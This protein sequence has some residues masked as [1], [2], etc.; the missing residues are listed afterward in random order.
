MAR[1]SYSDDFRR[2]AVRLVV[3]EG[4]ARKRVARDLGISP[5]SLRDW[6]HK[7]AP[8]GPAV[9]D[10][11]SEAEQLRQLKRENERLRMERDILKKAVGIFSQT[12]PRP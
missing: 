11:L 12:P 2:E 9:A 1:I 5:G 7:L 6:I 3:I 8:G 10:E 4:H